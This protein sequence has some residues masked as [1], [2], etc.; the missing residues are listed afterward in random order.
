VILEV[1]PVS[2]EGERVHMYH[3]RILHGHGVVWEGIVDAVII[4]GEPLLRLGLIY[5]AEV[6]GFVVDEVGK[7]EFME[8]FV[9]SEAER[10]RFQ[11]L[12]ERV[13]VLFATC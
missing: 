4:N 1:V 5:A 7:E 12:P 3:V 8:D 13:R 9:V 2:K 10:E 11:S 6:K